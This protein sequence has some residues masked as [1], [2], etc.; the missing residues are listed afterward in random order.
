[1]V[2]CVSDFGCYGYGTTKKNHNMLGR[3][4]EMFMKWKVAANGQKLE[5]RF[6]SNFIC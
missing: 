3:R 4:D 5:Q 1:M 2:G 6:L